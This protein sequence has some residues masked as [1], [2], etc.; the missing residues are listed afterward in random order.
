MAGLSRKVKALPGYFG[1]LFNDR[2]AANGWL[3]RV[4]RRLGHD[5]YGD[6]EPRPVSM[7][8]GG[9]TLIHAYIYKK[10]A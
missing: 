9:P 3:D 7:G 1:R 5:Y 10:E 8:D 2:D 6:M 4:L